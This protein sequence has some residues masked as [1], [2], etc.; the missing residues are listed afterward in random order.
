MARNLSRIAQWSAVALW[1]AAIFA[2]SATPGSALPGGYSVQAH[3]IEYFVLAALLYLALS[4]DRNRRVAL[5]VAIVLASAYGVTDEFHQSFVPMRMP[6]PIDW[7]IDTAG[8]VAG[9]L[10]AAWALAAVAGRRGPRQD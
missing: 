2:L 9:A 8:A 1:A 10:F 3:F 6:D 4:V 7:L 5:A